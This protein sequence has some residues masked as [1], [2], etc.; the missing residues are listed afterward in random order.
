MSG[1][2][3]ITP[4]GANTPYTFTTYTPSGGGIMD[5]VDADPGNT[6]DPIIY[7]PPSS[8]TE[9]EAQVWVIATGSSPNWGG[10][11]VWLSVD[12]PTSTY[13]QLGVITSGCIQGKSMNDYPI[14]PDPDT[15]D[16]LQIDLTESGSGE[17]LTSFTPTDADKS[18]SLCILGNELIA[19]TNA[20]L[21]STGQYQLDT[22]IRRGQYGTQ[23]V[24]HPSGER[25]GQFTNTTF[26]QGYRPALIGTPIYLKFPAFNGLGA[27]VQ[28]LSACNIYSY[29]LNGAGY[30]PPAWFNSFSVGHPLNALP[31]DT[32]DGNFEIFDVQM[33]TAV[34]LPNNF[35][36]SQLP[37]CEVPPI[38]TV[39]LTIQH[40]SATTY[41]N[42]GTLT[43]PG[44]YNVGFYTVP[45]PVTI[46]AGDRLRLFAPPSVDGTMSGLYGTI[47]GSR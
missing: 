46:P 30:S 15:F 13:G 37:G 43:I 4:I 26:I 28:D 44:G 6:N 36:T 29:T 19:F 41:Y 23:I 27:N 10:C 24:D 8:F 3:P 33:P 32:V 17:E 14:G 18:I 42:I 12:G 16:P 45:G 47:T 40:V 1:P 11:Q 20:A 35:A 2:I 39:T 25:F 21:I 22:Y 9:G 7:E 31:V 5:Q 38:G 34:L